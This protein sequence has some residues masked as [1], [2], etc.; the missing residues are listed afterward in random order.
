MNPSSIL[1]VRFS[2]LGDI[3]LTLPALELLRKK[4]PGAKITYLTK[5]SFAPILKNH[6]DID[7]VI[8]L[9][10]KERLK[11]LVSRMP[12]RFDV[13]VDW[14]NSFRSRGLRWLLKAEQKLA[15]KKP[16]FKRILLIRLKIDTMRTLP[17][18]F[19]RYIET[20][21]PLGI[22]SQSTVGYLHTEEWESD[23]E[24]GLVLFA[25]GANWFTKRWPADKYKELGNI[26]I[27]EGYRIGFIGSEAEYEVAQNIAQN[28]EQN[29]FKN[30]CGKI[31]LEKLAS[32][33]SSS[34]AVV[35]NDSA[36]LHMAAISQVP[37]IGIFTATT[38]SLGFTPPGKSFVRVEAPGVACRPCSHI[39]LKECPKAHFDCAEG[40]SVEKVYEA[41][42]Q[43]LMPA[44][45]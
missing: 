39:G 27:K 41:L 23:S 20:L 24:K 26:L 19:E 11:S 25:P 3:L 21:K 22:E 33:I 6:R 28:W 40:I 15:F 30:F 1:C 10:K 44:A 4:F 2:S 12:R 34:K 37:V 8:L 36:L 45:K 14:H 5:E 7:E 38:A 18:V 13:I 17:P 31:P 32:I 29:R 9:Q 42:L 16:Y 43:V 35:S